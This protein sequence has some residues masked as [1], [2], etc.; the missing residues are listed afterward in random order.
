MKI[1]QKNNYRTTLI[2]IV[3]FFTESAQSVK[4]AYT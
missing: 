2:L 3:S 4:T 1:Y